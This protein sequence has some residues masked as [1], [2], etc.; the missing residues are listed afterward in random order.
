[1]K[2]SIRTKT[3][4]AVAATIAALAILAAG[5]GDSG[6]NNGGES[7]YL[8]MFLDVFSKNPGH[9]NDIG[10]YSLTINTSEGGTVSRSLN[11][12]SYKA[13]A[14]VT[15]T[16][17]PDPGYEFIGWS[18][19]LNTTNLE[20]TITMNG[21]RW[22]T[23]NFKK[24]DD[25]R[26]TYEVYFDANGADGDVPAPARSVSGNSITLPYLT[27]MSKP[28]YRLTGWNEDNPDTGTFYKA[29]ASYTVTHRATLYA[30]W[31]R[32]YSVV[33]DCNGAN[34]EPNT[35]GAGSG[36]NGG[37]TRTE[38]VFYGTVI[39]LRSSDDPSFYITKNGYYFDGW[40]T[41]PDGT[42]T[43]YT[44]GSSYTVTDDITFYAKWMSTGRY[45]VV[46][47]S[48]GA[49]AT[50]DSVYTAGDT[51]KI[52]AGTPPSG[53]QFK[54]WIS[55]TPYILFAPT[56]N[57]ATAMF[58]MPDAAVT[59]TAVFEPIAANAH[60]H[61]ITFNPNGGTV[62]P[63]KLVT[64][65]TG[66]LA[67]LPTPEKRGYSFDGWFTSETGGTR[68]TAGA[69]GTV[70]TS[71]IVIY[72]RWTITTYTIT[73]YLDGG[74]VSTTNPTSYT[75]ETPT[76]TLNNPTKTG[77][78]FT[79]WTDENGSTQTTVIIANGSLGNKSYAANWT[80][81]VYYTLTVQ[82]N[83]T[84]GGSAT[85]SS[86][87]SILAGT[88][89]NIS[90]TANSGYTFNNWTIASGSG[91]IA[92]SGNASTTVTVNGNITVMANFTQTGKIPGTPI[93]F[94]G[95]TYQ[96]VVIGGKTWMAANLNFDTLPG[97]GSWCYGDSAKNCEKY[98]RLYDWSTA[99][100]VCPT[101]MGWKL[102]DTA[103][104]NNLTRW[105]GGKDIAAGRLKAA[106][107]WD[108]TTNSED[109]YG[110]SALPGGYYRADDDRE[111]EDDDD[112]SFKAAGKYGLW[113]T[114]MGQGNLAK[115]KIMS[116]NNG[117]VEEN[118]LLKSRGFS[119]R[120]VKND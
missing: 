39:T 112:E 9:N 70:F 111:G 55:S 105:L 90:A 86:L 22:L 85:V 109:N 60:A 6:I 74:T 69:T 3:V 94:K 59:V 79:G 20:L 104:W 64:D 24:D 28:G 42:G 115:A 21:D 30:K 2:N 110:F 62:T 17:V 103:D 89:I 14:S 101:A 116:Y 99:T 48:V 72:A 34:V 27:N 19:A 76:F 50:R 5:C 40:N 38:H 36:S 61:T 32:I 18:G 23:A 35:L 119:V 4:I 97:T 16:A 52:T 98:G 66:R 120:C 10:D 25:Y 31:E 45:R 107:G 44:V 80:T 7:K 57:N 108:S 102:P 41:K 77:F 100:K 58:I 1:M 96:T 75:V 65:T 117:K 88:Q 37:P 43:T 78:K 81:T 33:Y 93:T 73:Y 84:Y 47:S 68:V 113:W 11:V 13:G 49:N 54:E 92:N 63:N 71:D 106:S 118:E 15:V 82:C 56:A 26:P 83:P 67:R 53:Y 95:R 46:V 8:N 114:A 51:V 87:S 91:T 12:D 29:S